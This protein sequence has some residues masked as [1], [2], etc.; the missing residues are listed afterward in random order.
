MSREFGAVCD[1]FFVS[2]R[3]FLK[4]EMALQRDTVLHFFDRIRKDYSGLRKLR[5]RDGNCLVLEEEPSERGS[6]RWIRL[7]PDSLRF[8]RF[9]PDDTEDV[10]AFGACNCSFGIHF[11]DGK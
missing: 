6:R 4:L 11:A 8:G 5:R 7:D 2:S 9:G 10:F 3:L 1:D